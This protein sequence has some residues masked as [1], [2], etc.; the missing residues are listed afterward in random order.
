MGEQ[1][2]IS[3]QAALS[4]LSLNRLNQRLVVME[5]YFIA[6][7]HKGL[8]CVEG[9]SE[10]VKGEGEGGGEKA[11]VDVCEKEKRPEHSGKSKSSR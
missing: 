6:L 4:T 10:G 5:R 3:H 8:S 1:Q 9:E 11:E 2:D 7:S